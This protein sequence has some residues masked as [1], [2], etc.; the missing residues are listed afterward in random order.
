MDAI[1]KRVVCGTH[2]E[3][4]RSPYYVEPPEPIAPKV[5]VVEPVPGEPELTPGQKAEKF[6]RDV[7]VPDPV[8]A[9]EVQAMAKD[10]S[11]AL[12]TLRRA[13]ERMNVR[14]FKKGAQW[15]WELP[16]SEDVRP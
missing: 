14:V 9:L 8:P 3:P 5:P 15:F 4:R 13:R 6:L 12:R 2:V 11:I 10:A 7:L 16:G 1:A